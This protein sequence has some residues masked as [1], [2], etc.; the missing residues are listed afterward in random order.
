MVRTAF[1]QS[2][3]VSKAE[4]IL[5]RRAGVPAPILWYRLYFNVIIDHVA[6]KEEACCL[7]TPSVSGITV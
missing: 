7:R 3:V 4:L 1:P 6:C 5:Y 2:A